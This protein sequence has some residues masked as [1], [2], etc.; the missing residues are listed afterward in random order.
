MRA[1]AAGQDGLGETAARGCEAEMGNAE[2]GSEGGEGEE[3]GDVGEGRVM[4][5]S[6]EKREGRF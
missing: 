5:V 6:G 1:G 3:E 4:D 2:D